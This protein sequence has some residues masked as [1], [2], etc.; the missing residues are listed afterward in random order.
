MLRTWLRSGS[1]LLDLEPNHSLVWAAVLCVEQYRTGTAQ[2]ESPRVQ[3]RQ[4][5]YPTEQRCLP[6][7]NIHRRIF[8][9]SH[10]FSF[11]HTAHATAR[12]EKSSATSGRETP[13]NTCWYA[14]LSWVPYC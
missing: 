13:C 11:I 5:V 12:L 10:T 8:G 6:K 3:L 2:H 9:T 14:A 4:K 1:R 7:T